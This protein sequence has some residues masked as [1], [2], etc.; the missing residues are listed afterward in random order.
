MDRSTVEQQIKALCSK[1]MHTDDPAEIQSISDELQKAIHEHIE[2]LRLK[3]L[4]NMG[5]PPQAPI[6]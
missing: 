5:V 1:L 6:A 4:A 2:V 3:L